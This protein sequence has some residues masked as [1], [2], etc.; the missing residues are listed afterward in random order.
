MAPG[1]AGAC[2]GILGKPRPEVDR[3]EHGRD[4]RY[5]VVAVSTGVGL[6]GSLA[7]VANRATQGGLAVS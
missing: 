6:D 1:K 5:D 2:D 4:L 3:R 7:W